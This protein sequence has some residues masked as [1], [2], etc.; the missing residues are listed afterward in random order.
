MPSMVVGG[1]NGLVCRWIFIFTSLG[2]ITVITATSNSKIQQGIGNG[3]FKV[4]S[5]SKLKLGGTLPTNKNR[6]LLILFLS[7]F[8]WST[9]DF[10]VTA[11]LA[12]ISIPFPTPIRPHPHPHQVNNHLY[13]V[14]LLN[15]N[16]I[17]KMICA[18]NVGNLPP[19]LQPPPEGGYPQLPF[20]HWG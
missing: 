5:T 7:A 3:T 8:T 6:S 12:S 20:L 13:C 11:T 2:S 19:S 4:F 1:C 16:L 15:F 18:G 14:Q 17:I 10:A 9:R